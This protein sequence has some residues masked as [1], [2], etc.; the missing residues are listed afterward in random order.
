VCE[1]AGQTSQAQTAGPLDLE[2]G[3]G[4]EGTAAPLAV[5]VHRRAGGD[6]VSVTRCRVW[7][8]SPTNGRSKSR[9]R[10]RASA[11]SCVSASLSARHSVAAAVRRCAR[12]PAVSVTKPRRAPKGEALL[13]SS[14]GK[15]IGRLFGASSD[16]G[17]DSGAQERVEQCALRRR[18]PRAW[19]DGTPEQYAVTSD[20]IRRRCAGH[21]V[22]I[23]RLTG[24][25]QEHTRRV[26]TG[27]HG[28]GDNVA[29][30]GDVHQQVSPSPASSAPSISP[31]AL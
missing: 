21:S 18:R 29:R 3:C 22:D 7:P 23:R 30:L 31:P 9:S 10:R 8:A 28:P 15:R 2:D 5:V 25:V 19:A 14:P 20:E 1:R 17:L 4:L 16:R 6:P 12:C 27:G 24:R 11:R 13:G 26:A